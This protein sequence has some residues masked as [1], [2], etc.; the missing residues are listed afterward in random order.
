MLCDHSGNSARCEAIGRGV[1]VRAWMAARASFAYLVLVLRSIG[2]IRDA[3]I[4]QPLAFVLH[5][6]FPHTSAFIADCGS[7][8]EQMPPSSHF[9]S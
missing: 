8:E 5:A 4:N 7:V 2:V 6:R 1:V 9:P 3:N